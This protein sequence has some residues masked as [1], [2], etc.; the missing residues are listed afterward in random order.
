MTQGKYF[1]LGRYRPPSTLGGEERER[2]EIGRLTWQEAANPGHGPPALSGKVKW[3]GPNAEAAFQRPQ[4]QPHLGPV[5]ADLKPTRTMVPRSTR[6]TSAE[7]QASSQLRQPA[8]ERQA[9]PRVR[10]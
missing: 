10:M 6:E 7:A 3:N 4:R 1:R 9:L 2:E 8:H 5:Q